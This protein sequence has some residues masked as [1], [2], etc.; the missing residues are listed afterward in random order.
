M[1]KDHSVLS[2]SFLDVMT[3][4]MG[5]LLL[6]FFIMVA[7]QASLDLSSSSETNSGRESLT[8]ESS[9]EGKRNAAP[10]AVVIRCNAGKSLW[11]ADS[12]MLWM[13]RGSEFNWRNSHGD[14]YAITHGLRTPP[15]GAELWVGPVAVEPPFTIDVFQN[16]KRT[17]SRR[18]TPGD[19]DSDGMFRVWPAS[20]EEALP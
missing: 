9:I 20:G 19:I 15:Q 3:S 12:K 17:A 14:N 1:N 11:K 16:G 18:A 10:F 4:G 8:G 7:T 5:S 13:P 2:L 6:L